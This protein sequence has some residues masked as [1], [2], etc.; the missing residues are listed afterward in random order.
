M[1][2]VVMISLHQEFE[3]NKEKKAI[4]ISKIWWPILGDQPVLKK[5]VMWNCFW[6]AEL[7]EEFH[8]HN[9]NKNVNQQITDCQILAR[10]KKFV[11]ILLFVCCVNF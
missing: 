3:N 11:C 8:I 1:G 9:L 6:F 2:F 7:A 4:K 5:I 10:L